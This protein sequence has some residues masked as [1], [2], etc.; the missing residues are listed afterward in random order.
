[1]IFLLYSKSQKAYHR[2][3]LQEMISDNRLNLKTKDA[4][5]DFIVVGFAID[6]TNANAQFPEI[7]FKLG[8][9]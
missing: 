4:P 8:R 6:K 7:K 3:D 9:P 2:C 5:C 1:M